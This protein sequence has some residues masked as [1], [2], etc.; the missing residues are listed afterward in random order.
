MESIQKEAIQKEAIQNALYI[1][2]TPIGNLGDMT[3]RAVH[4]LQSVDLIAAED[5][6]HSK[7]LMFHFNIDTPLYSC[8]K[9]NEE[10]RGDFFIGKL[11][12]G[13]SMAII[14]DAGT[15][16][17]SDPGHR[18]VKMAVE[19]GFAV[20]PVCGASA[21]VAALSA[22]GFD[23]TRFTF[24]GFLPRGKGEIEKTIATIA[25]GTAIFYESPKRI[26][27]TLSAI[28]EAYPQSEVCLCNDLTKKYEKL[29][30][31]NIVDVLSQLEANENATRGEYACVIHIGAV[32]V[33]EAKPQSLESMLVEVVIQEGC[34]TKE[35]TTILAGRLDGV[36]KKEIYKAMLNLKEIFA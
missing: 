30:H 34:T 35:A 7:G 24:L 33:V 2:A 12:E 14:S 15:P 11:Q 3:P 17:I 36:S 32:P 13:K 26:A 18:L 10:K 1:V 25:P 29:Y 27:K 21:V 4:I 20:V 23:V 19:A 9:F 28:A 8:H 31:G 16:C 6:R 5:T 22:S